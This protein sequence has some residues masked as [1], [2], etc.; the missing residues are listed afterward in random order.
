MTR[1]N[2]DLNQEVVLAAPKSEHELSALP[3]IDAATRRELAKQAADYVNTLSELSV[4]SPSFISRIKRIENLGNADMIRIAGGS[5]RL[6]DRNLASN[7]FQG[8]NAQEHVGNALNDLKNIVEELTPTTKNLNPRGFLGLFKKDDGLNSYFARYDQAQDSLNTV[9]KS[10]LRGKDELLQDNAALEQ[11]RQDLLGIM[12]NLNEYAE[13]VAILEDQVLAKA[14]ELRSMGKNEQADMIGTDVLFTVRQK[15]SEIAERLTVGTQAYLAFNLVRRNNVELAK[16]VDRTRTT[17]VTALRTAILVAQSLNNQRS[18][19]DNMDAIRASAD[20]AIQRSAS[21][22]RNER[23]SVR[24]GE[25]ERA[26]AVEELKAAFKDVS[27]ALAAVEENQETANSEINQT[28]DVLSSNE[29][30]KAIKMVNLTFGDE[31]GKKSA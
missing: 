7:S 14:S 8:Q 31:E 2:D 11:E 22:V 16:G 26:R 3:E 25:D 9:V 5:K 1:I 6:L 10:L 23:S 27:E 15:R 21:A 12:Q 4:H 18:I 17:T 19:L 30:N 28:M 29:G 20:S 13:L 24:K